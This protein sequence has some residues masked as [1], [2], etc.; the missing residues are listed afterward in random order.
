MDHQTLVRSSAL[1]NIPKKKLFD[2]INNALSK[3]EVCAAKSTEFYST[4]DNLCPRCEIVV[5]ACNRFYEANIPIEYWSLKMERDFKGAQILMTKYN[6]ITENLQQTY[7]SGK[8]MFFAGS[9]GVGKSM[10]LTSILKK[11]ASKGFTSLYTTL[12]DA[13]GVMT[14]A[15]HEQRYLSR[16]EL[17]MVDYLVVDEVDPRFMA[18]ENAADLYART[19]EG[20]FRTR[21]QNKMPTYLATNSPN[22][23]ESFT[24][25]LILKWYQYSVRI[26]ERQIN[27]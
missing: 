7:A 14:Q 25:T 20:I 10:V 8:S 2:R 9:H 23:L 21:S 1:N 27:D 13:V 24:G 5:I 22:V 26:L 17:A 19:F 3:C 18:S 6:E 16:R 4:S 15:D 12:S 11:A